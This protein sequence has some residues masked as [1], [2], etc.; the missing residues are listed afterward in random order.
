M[1]A[2]LLRSV[3]ELL[4]HLRRELSLWRHTLLLLLLC[5]L[6][7]L[8]CLLLLLL[9]R[10]LLLMIHLCDSLHLSRAQ[11]CQ[12]RM[13]GVQSVRL[14]LALGNTGHALIRKLAK[15]CRGDITTTTGGGTDRAL[16]H[17]VQI[18]P[19]LL[20]A[21]LSALLRH[22]LLNHLI[23][24]RVILHGLLLSGLLLLILLLIRRHSSILSLHKQ[25][26]DS[27]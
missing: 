19:R 18:L 4:V 15:S 5:L 23:L 3:K 22:V 7:L 6:L 16:C 26:L 2:P 12:I 14:L 8:L 11:T 24:V 17:S 25:T 9:P 27:R 21:L 1:A 13:S 20:H 10:R